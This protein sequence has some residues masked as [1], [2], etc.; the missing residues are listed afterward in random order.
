M[1]TRNWSIRAKIISLLLV[2]LIALVVMWGLVTTITLGP[3]LELLDGQSNLENVGR[4][5][6]AF[7]A[8][9][10]AERKLTA[11]Y[12]AL[13]RPEPTALIAQRK[14]TDA[15]IATLRRL[16]TSDDAQGALTQTSR[17]LLTTLFDR[18]DTLADLRGRVD[19]GQIDRTAA[20]TAYTQIM[21]ASAQVSS[22]LVRTVNELSLI[23]I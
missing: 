21:D 19:R 22:S 13:T 18:L 1:R 3:G 23:H 2:P 11:V 12:L 17:Q 10:Q 5:M 14:E 15:A 8:Q 9:M 16:A 4:P 20:T 6:Q 7:G